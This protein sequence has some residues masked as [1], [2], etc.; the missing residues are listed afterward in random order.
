MRSFTVEVS[1]GMLEIRFEHRTDASNPTVMGIEVVSR[2]A[3]EGPV[4]T[5]PGK[6][7]VIEVN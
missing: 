2:E 7:F 5:S 4:L 3:L 6:P 1:D